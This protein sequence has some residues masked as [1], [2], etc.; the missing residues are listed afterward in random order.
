MTLLLGLGVPPHGVRDII[1]R[2]T[3]DERNI[4]AH[5]G[6]TEERAAPDRLGGL[7]AEE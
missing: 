4:C 2:S 1:G 7:L 3:L 5:S 6:V